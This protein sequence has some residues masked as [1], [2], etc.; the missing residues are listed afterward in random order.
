MYYARQRLVIQFVFP[1]HDTADT[2]RHS[3]NNLYL[4]L[5]FMNNY[6]YSGP[7]I[8]YTYHIRHLVYSLQL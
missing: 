8:R 2:Q 6:L 1:I 3:G 5:L 4:L 7:H